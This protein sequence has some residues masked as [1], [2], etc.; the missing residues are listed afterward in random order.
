MAARA[1]CCLVPWLCHPRYHPHQH[2]ERSVTRQLRCGEAG[3]TAY[4]AGLLD[5]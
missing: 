1:C 5:N 4:Q 3:D 2:A